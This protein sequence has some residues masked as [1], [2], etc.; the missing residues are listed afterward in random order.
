MA[1]EPAT[2]C[3]VVALLG[4]P[5]AGKSTLVNALV[6]QKVAIVSPKVQTTRVRLTGLAI[7]GDTQLLLVDTP[8]LFQPRRRLDRAMVQNAWEGAADADVIL[9]I[10]DSKAGLRDEVKALLETIAK[11]PE[12]RWLILNK[13]DLADKGRLLG[14]IA[15]ANALAPFAE[16]FPISALSGDGIPGLKK[17]LGAAMP[18]GPWLF[19]EDQLS[20][21][22]AR[23]MATEL[24]R[25]QLFLQLG[26]ELPYSVAVITE[27][28]EE[29][30]DGSAAIHA[31]ILV[32]RESQ[33]GMVVGA[34][35]AK[36]KAIG[37][38]ARAQMEELLGRR[39]H[40]FLHVKVK[41]G[42][43]EDRHTWRDLG[44]DWV[45]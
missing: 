21:A 45:D 40:L 8:G 43:A 32:E 4:A 42:W 6:G 26:Q 1:A 31:Q 29:R 10:V 25:E 41:P 27:K 18:P 30:P 13:V 3:G 19:P 28:F 24:V 20:D 16:T 5:N 14:L 9:A 39:T 12:P 23:L 17:A 11:R 2:R 22:P 34:R 15:E 33:K 36:V 37:E 38:A 7:E 35:G 44:M